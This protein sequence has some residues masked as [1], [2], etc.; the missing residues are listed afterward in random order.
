MERILAI[1]GEGNP[2]TQL[3]DNSVRTR[4]TSEINYDASSIGGLI[5]WLEGVSEPPLTCT[6]NAYR[7][8]E[9]FINTPMEVP[10]SKH[11]EGGQNG[12]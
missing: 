6:L 8:E 2:D 1:R 9:N 7:Y 12:D 10:N 5:N 11:S 3:G 4:S